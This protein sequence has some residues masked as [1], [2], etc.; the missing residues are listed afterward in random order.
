MNAMSDDSPKPTKAWE[1]PDEAALHDFCARELGAD[2]EAFTLEKICRNSLGFYL[3]RACVR[4]GRWI[5]VWT[6]DTC[7]WGFRA[8]RL[9]SCGPTMTPTTTT[10]LVSSAGTA[11]R[12][13]GRWTR[14]GRASSRTWSATRS[15]RPSVRPSGAV[16]LAAWLAGPAPSTA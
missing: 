5:C 13:A 10:T 2:P 7:G 3:V 9:T 1:F 16:W 12:P 11:R 4:A 6:G 8:E 14:P 15:V